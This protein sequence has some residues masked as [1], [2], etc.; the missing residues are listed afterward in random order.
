MP[1]YNF[2]LEQIEYALK[3]HDFDYYLKIK[4]SGSKNSSKY[5]TLPLE[6]AN[7]IKEWYAVN[8]D[9]VLLCKT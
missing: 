6:L 9:R 7:I 5:I 1:K 8:G 3:E 2:Y 4:V